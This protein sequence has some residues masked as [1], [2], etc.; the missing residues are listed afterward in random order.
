MC[1]LSRGHPT[2]RC[3]VLAAP[4]DGG[5]PLRSLVLIFRSLPLQITITP[6]YVFSHDNRRVPDA[7]VSIWDVLAGLYSALRAPVDIETFVGLE[8]ERV[9][10]AADLRMQ[11]L[12]KDRRP[13]RCHVVRNIDLLEKRCFLG[14]RVATPSEVPQH[15]TFGE[16]FVVEVGSG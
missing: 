8:K 14:I 7:F 2:A 11:L 3:A 12:K 13:E 10:R 16:V 4:E 15:R 1:A 6:S 9:C 5:K